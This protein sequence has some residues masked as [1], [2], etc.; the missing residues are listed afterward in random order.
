[1]LIDLDETIL[2]VNYQVTD[3]GLTGAVDDAQAVGLLVGLS[4]DT[5]A[6][7]LRIW[8]ERFRMQGPIIAERGAVIAPKPG[9]L[10]YDL[11][12]S[13]RYTAS[14]Q[15]IAARVAAHGLRIWEGNP[16]EILRAGFR[17]GEP[18]ETVVLLNS[19]R[20]CSLSF[21]V[22]IIDKSGQA[23]LDSLATEYVNGL[24]RGLY[25]DFDDLTLDINSAYGIVIAARARHTK[26]TGS[27]AL[28]RSLDITGKFAMI[29]NSMGDNVGGDIAV[30]YAVGNATEEYRAVANYVCERPYTAGVIEVLQKLTRAA[31]AKQTSWAA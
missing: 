14:Y 5:P 16:V 4:S 15:A 6:E 3:D 12:E 30:Q 27:Q 28:Q 24:V 11:G 19:L 2:G 10:E 18:G 17:L 1:V 7:A 22:R 25:P 21:F 29:G 20:R 8:V 23:Q 26:R 13:V 9:R 31:R